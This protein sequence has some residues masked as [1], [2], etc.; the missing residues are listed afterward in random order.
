VSNGATIILRDNCFY[1]LPVAEPQMN[2]TWQRLIVDTPLSYFVGEAVVGNCLQNFCHGGRCMMRLQNWAIKQGWAT[3][4]DVVIF[5]RRVCNKKK[6][7]LQAW[8]NN[9]PSYFIAT[10]G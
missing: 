4:K 3:T 9:E 1:S 5:T 7:V 2:K 10:H 6:F 8:R